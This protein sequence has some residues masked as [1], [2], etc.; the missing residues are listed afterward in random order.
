MWNDAET[1][2]LEAQS[3]QTTAE[4]WIVIDEKE[5][6]MRWPGFHS[7]AAASLSGAAR[8]EG[9]VNKRIAIADDE[10]DL[11]AALVIMLRSWNYKVEMTASEGAEI[12]EAIAQKKIWPQV[13]LM[14]Y[15][16]K[17]TNGLE[18]AKKI[19][20]LD[21]SIK[22]VVVSADDSVRPQVAEAG[23]AFLL[24]PY[25]SAQLKRTLMNL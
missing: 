13:V 21:P 2:T 10:E 9:T 23:L 11:L 17:A 15:R 14:D 24:K 5:G 6:S 25:S 16:M 1:R 18:A 8:E 20:L 12:V 4:T 3:R 22:V 7:R 19:L